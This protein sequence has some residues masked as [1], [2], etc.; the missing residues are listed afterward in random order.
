VA[1]SQFQ[2]HGGDD[3]TAVAIGAAVADLL[4]AKSRE[5]GAQSK[6]HE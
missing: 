5:R 2:E 4:E 1:F 6:N 3:L